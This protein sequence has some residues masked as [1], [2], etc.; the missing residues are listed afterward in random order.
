MTRT[1][2]ERRDR[3]DAIR[4]MLPDWNVVT[5]DPGHRQWHDFIGRDRPGVVWELARIHE[6]TGNAEAGWEAAAALCAVAEKYPG[7][8]YYYQNLARHSAFRNPDPLRWSSGVG[9]S[10]Y[11]GWAGKDLMRLAEACDKVFDFVKGNAELAAW[12][13]RHVAWVRTEADV[14]RFLD[15]RILQHGWDCV[16]RRII[17]NDEAYILLPLIQGPGPV[18]NDMIARGIFGKV[19]TNMTDAGGIDDQAFTSYG[20]G[21]VHYIGSTLY[22]SPKLAG[23]AELLTAYVDAGGPE[24]FNLADPDRYPHLPEATRT[25]NALHAA[26]GFPII[27]GD[28]MDL[29]RGRVEGLP[30]HPPRVI[31]GFGEVVLEAGR[32]SADPRARSAVGIHTGLGRGHAHQDCLNVEMFA[33]GCR[34]LPDL[35]GRHAGRNRSSPNMRRNRMHNVV[36]VDDEEFHNPYPGSTTGATGWT[37]SFS[38]QPGCQYT[39][40]AARATS[41]PQ[42]TRYA[43][44]TAMIDAACAGADTTGDVYVFDCFRVDGG[45]I[46]TYC[47]HGAPADDVAANIELGPAEGDEAEAVLKR[48]PR[49]S[50][51]AGVAAD[52][53][54]VTWPLRP[55]LQ[56]RYQGKEH[57]RPDRPVGLTLHLYGCRGEGVYVG[58]AESE[59][60]GSTPTGSWST[61]TARSGGGRRIRARATPGSSPA[62]ARWRP[63]PS[64][65]PTATAGPS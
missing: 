39:A 21:G 38:A 64:P 61:R 44:A 10:V 30:E 4:A 59:A 54:V 57:H 5:I 35:G 48:R 50:W 56:A 51:R 45:R 55:K 9:K 36:W 20:R 12:L 6:L 63:T 13:G 11:S 22:A 60:G 47:F 58:S 26:G 19:H 24:R 32:G 53:L 14:R 41:H 1:P 33:H 23:V 18:S 16:H 8:D 15:T 17:R 62:R 42:I 29:R 34:L 43:R 40:N 46:H 49:S 2:A 31:E 7:L 27:V 25:K 37:E 65:T 28:A 3:A 52:P